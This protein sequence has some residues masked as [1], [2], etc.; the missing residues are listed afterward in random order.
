MP[1]AYEFLIL[2]MSY[3][4]STMED[5]FTLFS[6]PLTFAQFISSSFLYSYVTILTWMGNHGSAVLYKCRESWRTVDPWLLT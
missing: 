4:L 2:D 5:D 3:W 6:L 1:I